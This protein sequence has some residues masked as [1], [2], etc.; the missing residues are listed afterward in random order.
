MARSLCLL[1]ANCQ[2]DALRLLLEA[3]PA[4]SKNFEIRQ[5]VNYTREEVPAAELGR[6]R[7]FLQQYLG[8]HWGELSS[9]RF[10]PR[11]VTNCER[12]ILPNFFFKGYWP[13]WTNK[14]QGINFADSL[15]EQLLDKGLNVNEIQHLYLRADKVLFGNLEN[16][17]QASLAHEAEKEEQSPIK[18][19][20]MIREHWREEQ[21]FVTVN[22]P[23]KKLLFHL[24][25]TIL[26][27]LGLGTLPRDLRQRFVSPLEDFWLP[28][29]PGVG[30]Q[31][32]LPFAQSERQYP[33][34]GGT[35]SHQEY[36]A[37]Y[38]ACRSQGESDLL[39]LIHARVEQSKA[40]TDKKYTAKDDVHPQK[41]SLKAVQEER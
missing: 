9:E 29:H 5:Y 20:Q 18:Y 7:L 37:C 16:I 25:D 31:L 13:F 10:L 8:P 3:T 4:F 36:I 23:G 34:F 30:R 2:G 15:L 6:A 14:F 17:A 24:A 41:L 1:H 39:G 28:I 11:L 38:L 40:S 35:M 33:V 27:M 21:L 26:G 19:V 32:G 22:H 12:I